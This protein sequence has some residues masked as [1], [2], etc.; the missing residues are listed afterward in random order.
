MADQ[1]LPNVPYRIAI[2]DENGILTPEGAA[3]FRSLY[4]RVGQANALTNLELQA[5]AGGA[6]QQAEIDALTAVVIANQAADDLQ[7]SNLSQGPVL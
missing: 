1:P 5:L 3:F 4:I 7:F 6:V 2:V